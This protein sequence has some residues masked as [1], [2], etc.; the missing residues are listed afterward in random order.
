[1]S[2]IL[3][4]QFLG[5]QGS[6]DFSRLDCAIFS[7]ARARGTSS[8]YPSMKTNLLRFLPVAGMVAAA[9]LLSGCAS[10]VDGLNQFAYHLDQET[11]RNAEA[12]YYAAYYGPR[13]A[14]DTS[15]P[16]IK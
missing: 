14:S 16:G 7:K 1:M 4:T 5:F 2:S 13:C 15:A 6:G 12:A 9:G 11:Q 8:C 3:V 10:V